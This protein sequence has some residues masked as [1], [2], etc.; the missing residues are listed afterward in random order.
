MLGF[1]RQNVPNVQ[2]ALKFCLC[3]TIL[4]LFFNC[5]SLVLFFNNNFEGLVQNYCNDLILYKEL[6]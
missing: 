5:C 2:K 3:H 1:V 6:G 4:I